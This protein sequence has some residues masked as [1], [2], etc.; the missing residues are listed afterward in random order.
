MEQGSSSNVCNQLYAGSAAGSEPETEAVKNFILKNKWL[1]VVSLHSFGG[2]WLFTP[3]KNDS[4][5]RERFLKLV[6]FKKYLKNFK[7]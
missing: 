7:F 3:L 6:I 1:S 4:I 5:K 2:F